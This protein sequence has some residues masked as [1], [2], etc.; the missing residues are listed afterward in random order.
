VGGMG[1]E[2]TEGGGGAHGIGRL[3]RAGGWVCVA[4]T[5]GIIRGPRLN[6]MMPNESPG[7]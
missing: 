3:L 4:W 5:P 7:I 1:G 6:G 2:G